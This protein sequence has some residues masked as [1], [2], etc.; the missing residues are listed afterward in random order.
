MS[1]IIISSKGVMPTFKNIFYKVYPGLK[2]QSFNDWKK[3]GDF[4][5]TLHD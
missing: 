1:V 2:L 5:K 3:K 4:G